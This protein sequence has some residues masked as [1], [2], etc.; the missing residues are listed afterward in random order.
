MSE[1][2]IL[3]IVGEAG[4]GKSE[5]CAYLAE[6]YGFTVVLVSDIIRKFA[7]TQDI[8]LTRRQDYLDVHAAMKRQQGVDIV[9]RTILQNPASRLCV[10]GI[11]V[12]NDVER[13]RHTPGVTSEVVAL[14]CPPAV[15]FER[16]KQ[17]GATLDHLTFKEFL[18]DDLSDAYNADPEQQNTHA[19]MTAADHR[20]DALQPF[21]VVQQA[22]DRIV[23]PL[24][25]V[26]A[27]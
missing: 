10:D 11:R 13:L 12:Q 18:A 24:L 6:E 19:V 16:A 9:A 2:T 23:A 3:Q 25:H 15:R 22:L 21:T 26:H 7:R 14:E 27:D 8:P 5:S 17:R 4:A 20:I 1:R